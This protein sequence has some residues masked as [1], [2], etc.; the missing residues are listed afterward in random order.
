MANDFSSFSACK[1]YWRFEPGGI[2]V[3]SISTN[4]LTVNNSAN[5][6]QMTAPNNFREGSGGIYLERVGSN[7]GNLSITDANLS[8]GF[9]FKSGDA[10]Q[11]ITVTCWIRPLISTGDY[12]DRIV[13]S[14]WNTTAG[15]TL[16]LS[17][18]GGAF[19]IYAGY[20]SGASSQSLYTSGTYSAPNTWHFVA[21]SVD[22]VNKKA[23]LL[24]WREA[25][26]QRWDR[27]EY[28][29]TNAFS[30]MSADWR[31]GT[32]ANAAAPY[33]GW[34]DEVSVFNSILSENTIEKIRCGT[35]SGSTDSYANDFSTCNN[36]K[37]YYRF[38]PGGL[39]T[40]SK[41][42]N[43]L[44]AS[45]SPPTSST[46]WWGYNEGTGSA[47]YTRTSSQCHYIT[48]ANLPS[49]FPTK[50]GET[51]TTFTVCFWMRYSS[52]TQYGGLVSKY[53][54]TGNLRSWSILWG[55]TNQIIVLW[56][57]TNGTVAETFN[58]GTS[59]VGT[60]Q[61]YHISVAFDGPN[62]KI[63]VVI[64][65]QW[66]KYPSSILE[67]TPTNT[68]SAVGSELRIG[69]YDGVNYWNG[70]IDEVVIFDKFLSMADMDA[71]RSG[72]FAGSSIK[73]P[74]TFHNIFA[75]VAHRTVNNFNYR[76]LDPAT[77][78]ATYNL[79]LNFS[80]PQ[81]CLSETSV[82]NGDKVL[83]AKTPQTNFTGT[84]TATNNSTALVFTNDPTSTGIVS[85][86]MIRI[87]DEAIPY[88]VSSIS[89]VNVTL[90]RPYQGTSGSG[91]N[92][93][94]INTIREVTGL[95]TNNAIDG[96]GPDYLTEIRGGIDTSNP[97]VANGSSLMVIEA[98]STSA[99]FVTTSN[100]V[101]FSRLGVV[102]A[103]VPFQMAGKHCVGEDLYIGLA[104]STSGQF[105]GGFRNTT[106]SRLVAENSNML[107][108][109]GADN[110]TFNDIVMHA[111]STNTDV[112]VGTFINCVFNRVRLLGSTGMRVVS[113]NAT[114]QHWINCVFNDCL[115]G[116]PNTITYLVRCYQNSYIPSYLDI[117]FRNCKINYATALVYSNYDNYSWLGQIRFE[118][119]NQISGNH[120]YLENDGYL[121]AA[122]DWN[123]KAIIEP[124]YNMYQNTAPAIRVSMPG[125]FQQTQSIQPFT[126]ACVAGTTTTISAYL[127]RNQ[128]YG[129]DNLPAM[130]TKY[131]TGAAPSV[132]RV[133]AGVAMSDV[134]D[135]W[136]QVSYSF[137]PAQDA[138][139]VEFQA[140]SKN[141]SARV[142]IS[143]ISVT[144]GNESA[145]N[146][147]AGNDF[148]RTH[149][150][151]A[152]FKFEQGN[153]LA[154]S[155]GTNTLTNA[156]AATNDTTHFM[157]G[158][159][160]VA[161]ASASTQ[162]LRIVTP[163]SNFPWRTG[164]TTKGTICAWVYPGALTEGAVIFGKMLSGGPQNGVGVWIDASYRL[165][166]PWASNIS[167]SQSGIIYQTDAVLAANQWFHVALIV[168]GPGSFF[169][170]RVYNY[171]ANTVN[172]YNRIT[173]AALYA[174]DSTEFRIGCASD[175]T[176][177]IRTFNGSIDE[178]V[179]FDRMLEDAEVDKI[180]GGTFRSY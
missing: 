88:M 66:G 135:S 117:I 79:G 58:C 114:S 29:I 96:S 26:I 169:R 118:D 34:I 134:V 90:Y 106:I 142:W 39:T 128:F 140:I 124:D 149:H 24:I 159:S 56:G 36:C 72:T 5:V 116:D 38:E 6:W 45:A 60:N 97:S 143:D 165:H 27:Y 130:V 105:P 104:Q 1:A 21:V 152:W 163:S 53:L 180:R 10:T 137:M 71:V 25:G 122:S 110:C 18:Y 156:N 131:N 12:N 102:N 176:T 170:L 20:N 167:G 2:T 153:L 172:S 151:I 43:H 80:Y 157:E 76:C 144:S 95:W 52:A 49:G 78:N 86:W 99:G 150:C 125:T 132:T 16:E 171:N 22:G 138:V 155:K 62:K 154:D 59:S 123:Y 74:L 33:F 84:I 92:C 141:P 17:I 145:P 46:A 107:L 109:V 115:F 94:Y 160:S 11:L 81:R 55:N 162:Y 121:R 54:A 50:S 4:T 48:D 3:D 164:T 177:Y 127:R 68:L 166:I 23:R 89:G 146:Y 64:H 63:L 161:L 82:G 14:K 19:Y 32:N 44:T 57:T 47:L 173:R 70:Y 42:T 75:Q 67:F 85:G 168:D 65:P 91:K 111:S 174:S 15:R 40:D 179:V 113:I 98:T 87:D 112:F 13:W 41:S 120:F 93:A 51:N 136:N 103:G 178:L 61:W 175:G 129:P 147:S 30:V 108:F 28:S 35:F 7:Y 69:S 77:G 8:S 119:Y 126:I 148:S 9:P 101:K 83:V 139:D 158:S 31:I 73:Q 37:A 100:S 133:V